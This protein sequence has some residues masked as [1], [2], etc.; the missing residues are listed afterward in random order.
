MFWSMQTYQYLQK[1]WDTNTSNGWYKRIKIDKGETR[2]CEKHD[3]HEGKQQGFT[4]AHVLF[5][6][7]ANRA[8]SRNVLHRVAKVS[9]TNSEESQQQSHH[10]RMWTMSFLVL[11]LP[12]SFPSKCELHGLP[13]ACVGEGLSKKMSPYVSSLDRRLHHMPG[14]LEW[15]VCRDWNDCL[16]VVS[17]PRS[18]PHAMV[19][20]RQRQKMGEFSK[21]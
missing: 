20:L 16:T 9:P 5:D 15:N 3:K 13:W 18:I 7:E 10:G 17:V 14:I 2:F 21:T 12:F 6:L 11:A 8:S 1:P 19:R 4:V